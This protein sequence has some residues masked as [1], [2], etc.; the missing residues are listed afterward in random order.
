MVYVCKQKYSIGWLQAVGYVD[1]GQ[2]AIC[3]HMITRGTAHRLMKRSIQGDIG[4][5]PKVG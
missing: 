5:D 3:K 2:G 1:V 4:K